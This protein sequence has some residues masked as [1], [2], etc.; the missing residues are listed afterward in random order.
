MLNFST[1]ARFE[2]GGYGLLGLSCPRPSGS[3]RF[4]QSHENSF[5]AKFSNPAGGLD[6][7]PVEI[8]LLTFGVLGSLACFVEADFFTFDFTGI[9]GYITGFTQCGAQLAVV[10]H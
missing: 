5:P 6:D 4:A 8:G 9:T 2:R 7:P 10:F 1:L 3:L